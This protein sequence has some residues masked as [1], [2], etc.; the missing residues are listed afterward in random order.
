MHDADKCF[1]EYS[2]WPERNRCEDNLK[3]FIAKGSTPFFTD[4]YQF[5]ENFKN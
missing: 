5:E 2:V 4:I 1:N 3:S